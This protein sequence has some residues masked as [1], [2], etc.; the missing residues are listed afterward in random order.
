MAQMPMYML[1]GSYFQELKKMSKRP[2]RGGVRLYVILKNVH[3]LVRIR[4]KI[5]LSGLFI[6]ISIYII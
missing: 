5:S 6:K 2:H 1:G 4:F 3:A